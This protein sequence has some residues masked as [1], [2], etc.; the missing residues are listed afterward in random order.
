VRN[1]TNGKEIIDILGWQK[2][3]IR[4]YL[5]AVP[6]FTKYAMRFY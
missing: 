1:V 2:I 5:P 4:Y 6:V 3:M